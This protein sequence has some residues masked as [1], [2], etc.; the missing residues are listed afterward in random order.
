MQ[1]KAGKADHHR[2]HKDV[3][4][5]CIGVDGCRA[6]WFS[7]AIYND[8]RYAL[9]C[10]GAIDD[11]WRKGRRARVILIDIPI[12]LLSENGTGRTVE[13]LA[14]AL[15]KPRRHA[16]VFSPPCREALAA[17][18]YEEACRINQMV[19]GRKISIQ[20]WHIMPKIKAVD[21]FLKAIPEAQ[22]ILRETHPEICFRALAGGVPM[23]HSKKSAEGRKERLRL[24]QQ[25]YPH[26]R[27]LYAAARDRFPRQ[28]VA[29]DDIIDALVNAVTATHLATAGATLPDYPP[30]DRRGLPMEMVYARPVVGSQTAISNSGS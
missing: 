25:A 27:T 14:R 4:R 23:T 24:L 26:A 21:D 12:G 10:H 9:D 17:A 11:L 8:G 1:R 15:L 7:V 22:G 13:A 16:S 18:T 2:S 19:C 30:L 5:A 29:R 3:A 6:G 28:D 20:T